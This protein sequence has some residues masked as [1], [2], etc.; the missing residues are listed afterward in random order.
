VFVTSTTTT[1]TSTDISYY[2]GFVTSLADAAGLGTYAGLPV[3]WEDLGSTSTVSAISREPLS[4]TA[5]IYML[6][7]TLVASNATALWSATLPT[8]LN[9]NEQG[10]QNPNG[11]V[12][13][14][15]GTDQ[16]GLSDPL[17]PLGSTITAEGRVAT[18][19]DTDNEPG[20]W[21]SQNNIFYGVDT[22]L[23][24]GISS[25]MTVPETSTQAPEPATMTVLAVGLAGL[26]V[27][28]RRRRVTRKS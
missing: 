27:A 11:D 20:D 10:N 1:A 22:A 9:I 7:G 28:R 2:D 14:W 21:I 5:P 8:I 23:L 13:V 4:D 26:G 19:T 3:T 15:T 18:G 6:D 25:I 24:Y 12:L 16:N 17:Y